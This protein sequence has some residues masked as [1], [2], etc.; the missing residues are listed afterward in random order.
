MAFDDFRLRNVPLLSRVGADRADE[1]RTDVDAAIA[2]WRDALLLRVDRRNQVLIADGRVVLGSA[3]ALGDRPP[4][5][6]VFLGKLTDGRHVWAIRADLEPP[7][8]PTVQAEVLDLRRAGQIFD[9]VSAQLVAT[10]TALLNW[11][12][13][14]RFSAVDGMPTKPIKG[15]WARI[16]PLTGHEEFPRIDPAIICLVHDGHDRAVLARQRMWPERLFSIL[17]GFVEAGESFETCVVREIAEEVGLSVSNVQYLGSQPWPFPRSL[18]VGFH[19]IADPEQPFSFND[20]EIAEAAWFT[21]DEI[22]AAL[23]AG[24]WNSDRSSSRLL[25]PGSISIAREI[26][27]SWAYRD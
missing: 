13:N 16:N 7:E 11:H 20:G 10:A 26:I 17:A 21:R 8:D 9:D 15:G 12:D 14:A 27:E 6:A 1:L 4:Q 18:M 5:D 22:R 3:A 2:G 24:D 25:L 23:E 19:A